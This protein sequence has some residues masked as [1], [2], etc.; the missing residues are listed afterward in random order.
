MFTPSLGLFDCLNHGRLAA[1]F[2]KDG[3]RVF[4]VKPDGFALTFSDA[5]KP[6]KIKDI[7]YFLDVPV[8]VVAAVFI[9]MLFFHIFV[10]SLTLRMIF[11]QQIKAELVCQGF[12][13]LICP[14]LHYD[15]EKL[16]RMGEENTSVIYCWKR[17]NQ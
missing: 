13:T 7:S 10:S 6:L 16:Y 9:T 2:T 14:P 17:Y 12:H 4:D 1:L 15:W 8:T 3:S 5:W 11:K